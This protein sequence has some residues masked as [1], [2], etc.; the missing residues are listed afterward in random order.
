MAEGSFAS[1]PGRDPATADQPINAYFGF[2]T[3][4]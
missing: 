3:D 2:L 1:N 4:D